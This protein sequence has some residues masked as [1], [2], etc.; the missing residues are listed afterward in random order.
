MEGGIREEEV[1][2]GRVGGKWE[3]YEILKELN[4]NCYF[5]NVNISFS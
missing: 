5:K 3:V 2:L 1:D 4:T